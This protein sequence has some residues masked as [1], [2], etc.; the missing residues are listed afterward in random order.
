MSGGSYYECAVAQK[1]TAAVVLRRIFLLVLY[2][3]WG[4]ACVLLGLRF[5]LL[6]LS[7]ELCALTLWT[8]IWLTWRLT[9]TD[10]EYQMLDGELS[11]YR[12]SGGR[13]RRRLCS[14]SVRDMTA[15]YPC[16]DE[17][18][19]RIAGTPVAR[20]FF[21]ASSR[22]AEDLYVAFW[23]DEK[24]GSIALYFEPDE[25]LCRLLRQYNITAVR[26]KK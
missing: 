20:R 13:S 2:A 22:D 14:V 6:L 9:H 12:I 5:D 18:T 11:V 19:A 26:L 24:K 16:T 4:V 10:Y 8:L 7:L 25:R 3:L 17:Y 15:V 1:K 21:A 23:N